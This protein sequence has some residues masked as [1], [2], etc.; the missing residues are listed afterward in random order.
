MSGKYPFTAFS[1]FSFY[2]RFHSTFSFFERKGK[3]MKFWLDKQIT[4]HKSSL[5]DVFFRHWNIINA[6]FTSTAFTFLHVLAYKICQKIWLKWQFDSAV[7]NP[8]GTTVFWWILINVRLKW[9]IDKLVLLR[10]GRQ[11]IAEGACIA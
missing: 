6:R 7:S 2:N 3:Q 9:S 11:M 4:A 1:L 8:N 5:Y 10:W